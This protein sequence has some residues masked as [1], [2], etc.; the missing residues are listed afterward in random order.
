MTDNSLLRLLA[1]LHCDGDEA[2][3]EKAV[4]WALKDRDDKSFKRMGK[5]A[6]Q[7]IS[8]AAWRIYNA[9]PATDVNNKGRSTRKGHADLQRIEKMLNSGY[10]EDELMKAIEEEKCRGQWLRNF[11]LFLQNLP[12]SQ[13]D[14]FSDN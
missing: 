14:N 11:S 10:S 1:Y 13:D 12:V 3:A 5:T 9:Y 6:L 4:E 7:D 2:K 8:E